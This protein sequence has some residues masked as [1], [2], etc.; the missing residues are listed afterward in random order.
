MSQYLQ[1]YIDGLMVEQAAPRSVSVPAAHSQYHVDDINVSS[2][3][4]MTPHLQ[5]SPQVKANCISGV[6]LLV[7]NYANIFSMC[8]H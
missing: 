6:S 1:L 2:L 7:S 8:I 4:G 3:S 5:I